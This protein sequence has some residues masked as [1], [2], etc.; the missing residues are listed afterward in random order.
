MHDLVR[1]TAL[2][3]ASKEGKAIKV[4]TKTLAEVEENVRVDCNIL[5]GHGESSSY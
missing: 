1:D 3:I 2:W 4:P 5:M